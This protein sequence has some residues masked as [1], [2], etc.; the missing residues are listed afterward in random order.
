ME[1]ENGRPEEALEILTVGLIICRLNDTLLPRL[2]KLNEKLH[3][4]DAVRSILSLLKSE[5]IEK[6]WKPVLEGCLFESRLG[7]YRI[8]RQLFHYLMNSVSWYGPIYFE[9]FKLEERVQRK[10]SALQIVKRGLVELPRYGPLWFGLLRLMEEQ[11]VRIEKRRWLRGLRPADPR[12][13]GAV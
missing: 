6:S 4:F 7:N 13:S 5:S 8:A 3:K 11:D 9:A 2:I 10:Q 12:G 1:E